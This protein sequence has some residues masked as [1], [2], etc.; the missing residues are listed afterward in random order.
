M[1][2]DIPEAIRR[3]DTL[4]NPDYVDLFTLTAPDATER[5]PEQWAR[6]VIECVPMVR[7]F[8]VWRVILGLRLEQR[9][10][11]ECLGG[12]RIADRGDS[13]IRVEAASWFMTA[14]LVLNVDEDRVSFATFVGY[15]RRVAALA[16]P[17]LAVVHRRAVPGLLRGAAKRV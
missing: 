2:R 12:W 4:P 9:S 11:P 6:A 5:S 15:D 13:W 8:L 14:H 10:S 7:G 1:Q 16:W 3:L 17:R